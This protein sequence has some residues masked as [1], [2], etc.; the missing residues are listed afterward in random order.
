MAHAPSACTA[1]IYIFT[2]C[3]TMNSKLYDNHTHPHI[4]EHTCMLLPVGY[5]TWSLLT[6][7]IQC[8]GVSPG[9]VLFPC[10]LHLRRCF[11]VRWSGIRCTWLSHCSRLSFS[12]SSTG[13]SP[14]CFMTSSLLCLS[15]SVS[16]RMSHKHRP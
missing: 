5:L 11:W 10:G 14:T 3:L 16:P 4:L 13:T 9:L 15:H 8:S 7:T 1:F 12:C 2:I 6:T